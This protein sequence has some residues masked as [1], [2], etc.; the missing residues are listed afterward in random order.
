[1]GKY[2]FVVRIVCSNL[3]N[4]RTIHRTVEGKSL[5]DAEYQL[6]QLM[7]KYEYGWYVH[8]KYLKI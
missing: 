7:V 3:K 8:E 4:L 6:A 5:E 1:M 2:L